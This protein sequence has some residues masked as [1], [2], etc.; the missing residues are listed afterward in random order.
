MQMPQTECNA[1]WPPKSLWKNSSL[2]VENQVCRRNG[3]KN[4]NC[5]R[6]TEEISDPGNTASPGQCS[7]ACGRIR[8]AQSAEGEDDPCPCR[9]CC[10]NPQLRSLLC[11]AH[12]SS[13]TPCTRLS[14]LCAYLHQRPRRLHSLCSPRSP[15]RWCSCSLE[16]RLVWA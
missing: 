4:E 12:S 6:G 16:S 1:S 9:P 11:R 3:M 14:F 2:C 8:P 5:S 15:E 7:G 10:H 13:L